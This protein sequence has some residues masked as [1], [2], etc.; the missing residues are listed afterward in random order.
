LNLGDQ[1]I[2]LLRG[3]CSDQDGA[4]RLRALGALVELDSGLNNHEVRESLFRALLAAL[5]DRSVE[6]RVFAATRLE[7]LGNPKAARALSSQLKDG[8]DTVRAACRQ[9]LLAIGEP[10]VPYFLDALSDRNRNSRRLGA[11]LLGEVCGGDVS[12]DSRRVALLGLV[13]RAADGNAEI[14]T[15]VHRSLETIPS[16]EV[17]TEQ[18]EWLADPERSDH[19]EIEE[20]LT[21]M[22]EQGGLTSEAKKRI[23]EMMT[24]A[25]WR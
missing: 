15:A 17:I 1:A 12:L 18:L 16:D 23:V 13:D 8:D 10:A 20:F 14:A 6:C 5:G 25:N 7:A 11:E 4:I 24:A 21:Q 3:A 9:A 19:E 22:V 2:E